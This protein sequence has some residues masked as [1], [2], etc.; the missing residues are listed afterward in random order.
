MRVPLQQT[1]DTGHASRFIGTLHP[2]ISMCLNMQTCISI[3]I[4]RDIYILYIY[5]SHIYINTCISYLHIIY[6]V[7]IYICVCVMYIII[8]YAQAGCAARRVLG[9]IK[10][11]PPLNFTFNWE[12]QQGY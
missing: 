12:D 1:H 10:L 5:I 9:N 11:L 7:C 6:T 8:Y 3:Y 2:A 4:Y